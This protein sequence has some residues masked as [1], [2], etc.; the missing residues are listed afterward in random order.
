VALNYYNNQE[1]TATGFIDNPKLGRIYKTG[2]TGLWTRHGYIEFHGRVDSQVK[3]NGHRIELGEIEA[4]LIKYPGVKLAIVLALEY[5]DT[6]G[7]LT[8]NKYLAAYYV[9]DSKIDEMAML[10][11]LS[12]EFPDYM[13]PDILIYL[14]E[15]PLT[16]NGKLDRKSLPYPKFVDIVD[17]Y[18]PPR[19]E[20]DKSLVQVFAN[21][22]GLTADKLSI[23]A[24]F[25]KLG[26]NSILAIKL[27]TQINKQVAYA[28]LSV[29]DIFSYKNIGKLSDYIAHRTEGSS[30]PEIEINKYN[31][32]NKKDYKLSFPQEK[33]WLIANE[34]HGTNAYNISIILKLSKNINAEY[35]FE[36]LEDVVKRHEVLRSIVKYDNVFNAYQEV[37]EFRARALV[38]QH[39]YTNIKDLYK[40]IANNCK[41][42]FKL[43]DEYPLKIDFYQNKTDKFLSI[44]IHHIAFDGWSIGVL[45][46]ELT[47]FYNYYKDRQNGIRKELDITLLPFQYKDFAYWQRNYFNEQSSRPG[48]IY[49]QEQLAGFKTLALPLDY[50]RPKHFDYAGNTL[51]FI[52]DTE[53]SEG[54]HKLSKELGFSLYSILLSGFYLLLNLYSNQDDIIL[55]T[56]VANRHYPGA[57]NLIGC[58]VN[59]LILRFKINK[60]EALIDFLRRSWDNT[61]YAQRYQ[62]VPV[63]KIIEMIAV[64]QDPAK[65]AIFQVLFNMLDIRFDNLDSELFDKVLDDRDVNIKNKSA[66]FDLTLYVNV[67]TDKLELAFNYATSLFTEASINNCAITYKHILNQFIIATN[68][69]QLSRCK[70]KE[71]K[72]A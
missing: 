25:F 39:A 41:Y 66:K 11:C 28:K 49:W 18:V 59:I 23:N 17:K 35:L 12:Q 46:K 62:E 37:L 44:V 71:I 27:V 9:A 6:D 54:L 56:T 30:Y 22:F 52:C 24:N 32:L 60:E 69:N 53:L 4:Q 26:G 42:V 38:N 50:P 3:I 65:H 7:N 55:G 1:I 15:L 19:D 72:T 51:Y 20:L 43:G 34:N 68:L 14:A 31:L 58:F 63:K 2:D 21:T 13:V 57:E 40:I 47:Q 29:A 48:L 45:L 16:E 36:A 67:S 5:I 33:L 64:K 10:S 61:I 8:N 70:V